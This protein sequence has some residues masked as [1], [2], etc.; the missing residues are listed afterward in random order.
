[1]HAG[2]RERYGRIDRADAAVGDRAAQ[3][4]RVQQALAGYIVDILPA[5]AQKP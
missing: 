4:R 1:M 3:D 5:P 2:E